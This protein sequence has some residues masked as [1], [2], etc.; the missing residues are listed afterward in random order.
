[1][2]LSERKRLEAD[3][4]AAMRRNVREMIPLIG[5]RTRFT[6]M[7]NEHGAAEAWRRLKGHA[8]IGFTALWEAGRL[9]LSLEALIVENPN[10]HALFRDYEVAEMRTALGKVDTKRKNETGR[11]D[12]NPGHLGGG[13]MLRSHLPAPSNPSA[14]AVAIFCTCPQERYAKRASVALNKYGGWAVLLVP[15]GACAT[16]SPPRAC[17]HFKRRAR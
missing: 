1:M 8:T 9:D 17:L 14:I 5:P 2:D 15:L 4:T 10:Y 11:D 12:G 6:P 16:T 3:F 13:A 7:L